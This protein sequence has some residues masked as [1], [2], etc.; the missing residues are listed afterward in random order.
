MCCSCQDIAHVSRE[1]SEFI[2]EYNKFLKYYLKTSLLFVVIKSLIES[3]NTQILDLYVQ[4]I[5]AHIAATNASI[6]LMV[7][8]ALLVQKYWNSTHGNS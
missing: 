1:Y 6:K 7:L 4:G 3:K 2:R 8:Y 5:E